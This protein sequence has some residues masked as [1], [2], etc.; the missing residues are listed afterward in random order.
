MIKAL[1]SIYLPNG[2]GFSDKSGFFLKN[3]KLFIFC[4]TFA[5]WVLLEIFLNLILYP[6]NSTDFIDEFTQL[7]ILIGIIWNY[8]LTFASRKKFTKLYF[9]IKAL[10]KKRKTFLICLNNISYFY[11]YINVIHFF[12]FI[13]DNNMFTKT[14]KTTQRISACYIYA[15]YIAFG[16]TAISRYVYESLQYFMYDSERR[17]FLFQ[18]LYGKTH[19]CVCIFKMTLF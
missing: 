12:F 15:L 14:E 17:S 4:L 11:Y 8:V 6:K 3:A 19:L 7:L 16:I 2:I 18:E 1:D 10:T 13:D 5:I 9:R